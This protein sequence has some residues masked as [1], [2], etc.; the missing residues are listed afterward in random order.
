MG[1]SLAEAVISNN[2]APLVNVGTLSAIEA[3]VSSATL[4]LFGLDYLFIDNQ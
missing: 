3:W 2:F 4:Q 1:D